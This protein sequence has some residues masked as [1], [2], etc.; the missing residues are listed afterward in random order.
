MSDPAVLVAD[1]LKVIDMLMPGVGAIAVEDYALLT[2]A[3]LRA[4]A[5]LAAQPMPY[6]KTFGDDRVCACGHVYYRHFDTYD[7]MRP[8]GCKYCDCRIFAEQP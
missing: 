3:P 1:L 4:R 8:V 5:W 2:D 6:D 7:E